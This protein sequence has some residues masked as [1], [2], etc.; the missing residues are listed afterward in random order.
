MEKEDLFTLEERKLFLS[1]YRILRRA[2]NESIT[3]DDVK[4][5]KEAIAK[6]MEIGCYTRRGEEVHPIIHNMATAILVTEEIGLRR[7]SVLSILLKETLGHI[8]SLDYISTHFGGNVATIIKGLVKTKELYDRNAAVETENFR[9]LLMSFAEDI[10][11]ILIM[12]ADRVN[13]MRYLN[14]HPNEAMREQVAREAS[15]LYAPLA[16]K[17]GLYKLKSEL[18]DTSLKYLNRKVYNE[19]ACKLNETKRSRDA[20]VASFIEPVKAKLESHG[21][22]FS[23]KGRTKSIHSIYTKMCKQNVGVEG[24]YDLFAIRIILDSEPDKE[25]AECWMAYSVVT[26][27]YPPNTKRLRD[28]L[29]IPKSNGYESLH[30]TVMGPQGKWVEVQIR[31]K[32]MDEIAERGLAAH[33]KYKG[34]KSES[35]M[36]AWLA[37]VR[38]LL[39]NNEGLSSNLMQEFKLDLYDQEVFV[40]T[41]KGEL[42]KLPKGAT[43]LDFAF[44]IH[45]ALGCKCVGGIVNGKNVPLKYLLRNG[46]QIVV[47]TSPNQRPK[48]G[49]INMVITTKARNKIKQALKE[50]ENRAAEFG[51]EVFQR[52]LK[53]RKLEYDDATMMR[54]IRKAGYKTVTDFYGA[55]SEEKQDI[56]NLIDW[57][58]ELMHKD[59]ALSQT[60]LNELR[61]AENYHVQPLADEVVYR[62]EDVL[63][64]DEHLKDVDFKLAKCCSPIYGD[65]VF[66][67]VS[68]QGGIKIHR[69]DCPNAHDM[70]S[71]YGYRIV[72]ACWAGKSQT[73]YPIR[74]RVVGH[75]DIGIVTN[76]TSIISKEENVTLRSINIDSTDD[77]FHG[78][79]T[80]MIGD[81]TKLNLLIKKITSVK[82]IKLAERLG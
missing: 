14:T 43:L 65:D 2:L 59:T 56:N 8:Y 25:K 18:E 1:Q 63:V 28:W 76:I 66:G 51:K 35:G 33:W 52:R 16:H 75:D 23:I 32:R 44:N 38:E 19:I 69:V 70:L 9:K 49:W 58:I 45:S 6:A 37:N 34:G 7:S 13:L 24:I 79:I 82:G 39:E 11:V 48:A 41:P 55:I 47:Q 21:L 5:V 26:D 20:Y 81:T 36:D 22:K 46:D 72:K 40:F 30:I 54:L 29:S 78:T 73:Q 64:I 74:I 31:T 12:I 68:A 77:L 42:C 10:R 62:K 17:L 57:Y 60:E 3:W 27:M 80:V 50:D 67:F 53:N 61:K 71:R 4:K 15:Y